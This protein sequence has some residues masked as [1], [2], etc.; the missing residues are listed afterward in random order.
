MCFIPNWRIKTSLIS[1]GT[2]FQTSVKCFQKT[3]LFDLIFTWEKYH[4]TTHK[5][6]KKVPIIAIFI[7]I[8]IPFSL[9][10]FPTMSECLMFAELSNISTCYPLFLLSSPPPMSDVWVSRH[11]CDSRNSPRIQCALMSQRL[12]SSWSHSLSSQVTAL[13]PGARHFK[14]G[15][16][17]GPC[18]W[19]QTNYLLSCLTFPF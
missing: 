15:S 10:C 2:F 11:C 18:P 8:F 17:S 13:S 14:R 7:Q 16:C 12:G 9:K 4:A 19:S 6:W 5:M 3:I 1:L